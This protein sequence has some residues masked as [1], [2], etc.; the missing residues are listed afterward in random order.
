MKKLFIIITAMILCVPFSGAEASASSDLSEMYAQAELLLA[1][2][3]YSSAAE[4]F[5]KLTTYSDSSQMAM[6]AKA[7][8]AAE[9]LELYDIAIDA[10]TDLGDFK[11]CAQLVKYYTGRKYQSFAETI[12]SNKDSYQDDD[13]SDAI[14]SAQKAASVYKD[15]ALFKDSMTR[16]KN[17]MDLEEQLKSEQDQRKINATDKA[18]QSAIDLRDAG[19]YDAAISM[20]ESIVP[21]RDTDIQIVETKYLKGLSLLK[22]QKYAE[23]LS[24]FLDIGDAKECQAEIKETYYYLGLEYLEQKNWDS[25]IDA[26]TKAGD[27][28]DAQEK[29]AFAE[30][31]KAAYE[32]I[33]LN[34]SAG[35]TIT[36]GL[37]EQD[38]DS[39]DGPEPIEW[40]VL[41]SN[42]NQC[43]MIS[44]KAI[45]CG[46]YQ[47]HNTVSTVVTWE[48]SDIRKYLNADF[49]NNA[50][51]LEDRN[52]VLLTAVDNS[53]AQWPAGMDSATSDPTTNDYVFLLSYQEVNQYF[54]EESNRICELTPY[55]ITKGVDDFLFLRTCKSNNGYTLSSQ[56]SLE[57]GKIYSSGLNSV[58]AFRPVIWFNYAQYILDKEFSD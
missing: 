47:D 4:I 19:Q 43:M 42:D 54:P 35:E 1:Q 7:L 12:L 48:D 11:D 31:K 8:M 9:D 25:A 22:G 49:Y 55:V 21:Y 38:G 20:F 45:E 37:Y 5:D 50:F 39:S 46:K 16:M 52:Y 14:E 36:F 2:G 18:Y 34:F 56:L 6:Y 57:N 44:K 29:I 51:S 27:Y 3:E 24:I 13:I 17:C 53:R 58:R 26:L 40:V 30:G 15:L 33:K 41:E 32:A 28:S 23:A 10:F